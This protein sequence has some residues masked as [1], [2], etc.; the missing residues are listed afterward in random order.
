MIMDSVLDQTHHSVFEA[1]PN[2]RKRTE[3]ICSPL[4]TEDYV[5]QSAEDVS[6]PRWH[7]AHTTW[8]F[9]AFFLK[10]FAPQYTV[11][12]VSYNFLFNSYYEG[13]GNRWERHARGNLSR[14]L[15]SDIYNYR[16]YV[17][18]AMH[19]LFESAADFTPEMI[20]LLKIGLHH[21]QQH[22]ELLLMDIKHNLYL[23]P[24]Y[25]AYTQNGHD[26]DA[27]DPGEIQ[28]I[29][30]EGTL[31]AAGSSDMTG[32]PS[33]SDFVFDNECPQHR[34]FLE[35]Y[36]MSNRPVTCYEF[37]EFIEDGGY[38]DHRHWL[39]DGWSWVNE[40]GISAPLYWNNEEGQWFVYTLHGN[41]KLNPA[42]PVCHV[43]FYEADAYARWK[44]CRLPTEFEWEHAARTAT[45]QEQNFY[46]T[47]K[48]HPS[49]VTGL[50]GFDQMYG[51]VWE[52]TESA[53]SAYPGFVQWSGTPGEYNGKF[54]NNQRVLRGG[55][56]LTPQNHFRV[57]YRN[58]FQPDK[59]WPMTGFRLAQTV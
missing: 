52:W 24:G 20:K 10:K 16:T 35:P 7:I 22:Q 28:M 46:E 6:P 50:S 32:S 44:G 1:Y 34:V 5:I 59:R 54:M 29:T 25:P 56:A 47:G 45:G 53:Y 41:K 21:E 33:Y 55:C 11:F 36:S 8:F 30:M 14:P 19:S 57:T 15:V 2:V 9:E 17:D 3:E 42:E 49:S 37:L 12:D 4:A 26:A 43:S 40:N 27:S 58:F 23:H 51:H 31:T 18:E 48:L 38:S 13:A 39:S